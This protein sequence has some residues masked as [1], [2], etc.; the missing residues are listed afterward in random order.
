[1]AQQ[2]DR[3]LGGEKDEGAETEENMKKRRPGCGTRIGIIGVEVTDPL[4]WK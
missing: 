4:D 3:L 2:K 1:V